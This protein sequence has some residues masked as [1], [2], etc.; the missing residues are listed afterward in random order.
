MNIKHKEKPVN[1][2]GISR[3]HIQTLFQNNF[4]VLRLSVTAFTQ[5]STAVN[6]ISVYCI[7]ENLIITES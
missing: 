4:L 7:Y 3:Q 2:S 5:F 1:H 6:A